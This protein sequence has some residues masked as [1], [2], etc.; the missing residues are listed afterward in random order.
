MKVRES[1]ARIF[2]KSLTYTAAVVLADAVIIQLITH[3]TD[4]TIKVL[5]ITN[6]ASFGIYYI[7]AHI[8]NSVRKGHKITK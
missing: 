7:H 1:H 2:T 3:R 8:W 6:L 4:A 5:V